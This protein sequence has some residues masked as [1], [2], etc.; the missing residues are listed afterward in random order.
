MSV[1]PICM[2]CSS[3]GTNTELEDQSSLDMIAFIENHENIL[4]WL[5]VVSGIGF[6][7]SI[8]L[9][10]W[11]VTKIPE[12]Y[13]T[14]QKRQKLLWGD[15]PKI[16]RLIF[17]FLKNIIGVLLIIGGIA[18]LFLPGQ[19]IVTILIGLLIMDFPYKYRFEIWIIKHPFVLK[20]IN[21]L[22]AKA[23]QR[24]LVI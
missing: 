2:P 3:I 4:L 16:V 17:I 8:L 15:Q 18:L 21:R 10:P 7:A 6:I 19:G 12:D 11:I 20:S 13:F 1:T 23:K 14:H 22:R 5:T 9:I 24:P